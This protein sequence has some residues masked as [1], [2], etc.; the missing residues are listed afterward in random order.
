MFVDVFILTPMKEKNSPEMSKKTFLIPDLVIKK[1]F[2]ATKFRKEC[3][4]F[5]AQLFII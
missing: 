2:H 1:H 3:F 5:T 4:I